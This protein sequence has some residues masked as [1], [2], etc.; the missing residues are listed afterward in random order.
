MP[1]LVNEDDQRR[2][3]LTVLLRLPLAFPH[4]VWLLLWSVVAFLAAIANW[5]CALATGRSPRPLARFLSAY[6]RY[7]VHVYAFLLLIGNP[8]PG[9]VGKAGSYPVDMR[10]DPFEQQNRWKT[11]FRFPA[12]PGGVCLRGRGHR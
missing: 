11:V 4:I 5:F 12:D 2:S 8:F 7:T 9:F 1:R 10:L 6:V 3:R